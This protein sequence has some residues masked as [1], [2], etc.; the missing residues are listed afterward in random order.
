MNYKKI[1]KEMQFSAINKIIKTKAK[2]KNKIIT[3]NNR[4]WVNQDHLENLFPQNSY[5]AKTQVTKKFLLKLSKWQYCKGIKKNLKS[6]KFATI[7]TSS[8][9]K[10]INFHT[11]MQWINSIRIYRAFIHSKKNRWEQLPKSRHKEID[12]L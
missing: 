3:I 9:N 8:S 4:W 6:R 10:I 11:K 2:N 1:F 12:N 7:Q 5:Q